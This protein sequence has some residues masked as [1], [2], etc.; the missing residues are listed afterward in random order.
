M[1]KY[2]NT[3]CRAAFLTHLLDNTKIRMSSK[4]PQILLSFSQCWNLISTV[5]VPANGEKA[6]M[7]HIFCNTKL[8]SYLIQYWWHKRSHLDFFCLQIW[9]K[10]QFCFVFI[11]LK[12]QTEYTPWNTNL[13]KTPNKSLF[14]F[15]ALT[16]ESM[17]V[18]WTSTSILAWLLDA[19]IN[20]WLAQL[21][22][23]TYKRAHSIQ[24]A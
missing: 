7:Q 24:K 11:Y 23:V 15:W 20:L 17:D 14:T 12:I 22:G 13:Y 1:Q 21:S 19:V 2:A 6:S 3:A 4:Y 16:G 8:L 5:E 10:V 9:R 18:G